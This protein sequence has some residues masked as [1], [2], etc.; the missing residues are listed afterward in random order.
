MECLCGKKMSLL[1]KIIMPHKVIGNI[2]VWSCSLEG[3]GRIY[4]DGDPH[5]TWYLPETNESKDLL[6]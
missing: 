5:G 6:G 3:C 4:L 2:T 1:G